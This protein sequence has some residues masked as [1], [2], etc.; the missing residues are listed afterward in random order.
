MPF[1]GLFYAEN[2]SKCVVKTAIFKS[3]SICSR[4]HPSYLNQSNSLTQ[5]MAPWLVPKL[6]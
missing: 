1:V 2:N 3:F 4:D 5:S 6:S